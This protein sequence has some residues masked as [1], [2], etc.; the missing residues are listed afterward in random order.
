MMPKIIAHRGASTNAPENTIEA[1]QLAFDQGADGVE[2][3]VMLSRDGHIVVFHDKKLERTTNGAGLVRNKTL[4]ELRSLDAGNGQK[5]STLKEVLD[6][7]GGRFMI[8]IEL[9]NYFSLFD[10]LPIKVAQLVREY[11]FENSVMVSSFNPFNLP[12]Y[13][14]ADP[15]THLG[16]L[17]LPKQ[18]KK[19]IWRLFKFDALHPYFSDVD[20]V[21]VSAL[22]ARNRKVNVWEVDDP[23]EI[24]RLASLGVDSIITNVPQY[25]REVLGN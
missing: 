10:D 16:L 20:Q 2:L 5:I 14:A 4:A 6:L 7:F 3:D 13:H 22:H 23:Q 25:A 24:Q 9:R 19:W 12:R 18:A 17:T 11:A 21:L 8:N 1:F 15:N